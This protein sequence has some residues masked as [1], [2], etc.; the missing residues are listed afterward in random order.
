MNSSPSHT[1]T[2][3]TAIARLKEIVH[4]LERGNLELEDSLKLFEEGIKLSKYCDEKLKEVEERLL[5]LKTGAE[6]VDP[7]AQRG[8]IPLRIVTPDELNKEG[9]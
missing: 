6:E 4:K 7:E 9:Q 1:Q 3:E 5:V 2:Y 8:E